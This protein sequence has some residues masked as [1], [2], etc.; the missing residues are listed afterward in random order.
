M[1]VIVY[2]SLNTKRTTSRLRTAPFTLEIDAI[3]DVTDVDVQ[4]TIRMMTVMGTH[5]QRRCDWII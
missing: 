5:T 2:T 4:R 1:T 3:R